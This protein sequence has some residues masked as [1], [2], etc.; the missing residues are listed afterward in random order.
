MIADR[1]IQRAE[2]SCMCEFGK[3]NRM[4]IHPVAKTIIPPSTNTR[5]FLVSLSKM[6]PPKRTENIDPNGN[7]EDAIPAFPEER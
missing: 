1:A 3:S 6:N 4:T 5:F 2:F 7:A